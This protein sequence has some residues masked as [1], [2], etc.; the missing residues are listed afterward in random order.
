MDKIAWEVGEDLV[1]KFREEEDK[2]DRQSCPKKSKKDPESEAKVA[3]LKKEQEEEEHQREKKKKKKKEREGREWKER[4]ER[5]ARDAKLWAE[6][7]QLQADKKMAWAKLLYTVQQEKYVVECLELIAYRKKY[8]S[9][10]QF[11]TV[12]L[13]SHTHYLETMWKDTSLYPHHNV[14]LG[15]QLIEWLWENNLDDKADDIQ[16]IIDK[17]LNIHAPKDFLALDALVIEP[18]YFIWVLQK[19][20]GHVIN[21]RDENY[22]E[23]QNIHLHDLVSQLSM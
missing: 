12:N 15:T 14:M 19:S 8:V 10:D 18:W 13:D 1:W 4:E 16:A 21:S 5:E 7:V 11:S 9:N 2:Q 6:K 20:N 3:A 22:G 17:G 23:D